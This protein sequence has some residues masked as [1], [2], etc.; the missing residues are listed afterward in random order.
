MENNNTFG[1]F[2][3]IKNKNG[4]EYLCLDDKDNYLF[5]VQINGKY[6]EFVVCHNW[7]NEANVWGSAEYFINIE[8]ASNYFTEKVKPYTRSF[9]GDTE[10]MRDFFELSKEDFLDTYNY[11]TEEDYKDTLKELY[12]V[13][14]NKTNDNYQYSLAAFLSEDPDYKEPEPVDIRNFMRDS[15]KNAI[16]ELTEMEEAMLINNVNK[17]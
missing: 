7:D 2:V 4:R 15:R 9:I 13:V 14:K 6:P 11:L 10:K 1:G 5:L 17:E 8:S 16:R 3:I 12:G